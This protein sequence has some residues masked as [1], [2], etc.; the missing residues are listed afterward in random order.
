MKTITVKTYSI[1]ELSD[2]AFRHAID[3]N[4]YSIVELDDWW[5][6]VYDNFKTDMA[7]AG[8]D[9]TDI[10]FSGFYSQ[11]DG[12]SFEANIPVYEYLKANKLANK[13]RTLYKFAKEGLVDEIQVMYKT[14]HYAHEH[15]MSVYDNSLSF[16]VDFETPKQQDKYEDQLYRLVERIEEEIVEKAKKLYKDLRNEYEILTSEDAVAEDLANNDCMFDERGDQIPFHLLD[17]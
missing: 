12:A 7:Q 8:Y 3:E 14:D 9:V 15:T 13:Y 5:E 10:R 6:Y 16:S 2:E 1:Q 4:R 11:G 17:N